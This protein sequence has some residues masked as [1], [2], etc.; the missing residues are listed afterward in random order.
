MYLNTYASE[1]KELE[2]YEIVKSVEISKEDNTYRIEVLRDYS[3]QN[4]CFCVRAYVRELVSINRESF[5]N[6]ATDN[7]LIEDRHIWAD[8]SDFPWVNMP[9]PKKA[10]SQA[11]GFLEERAHR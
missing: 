9:D 8:F 1:H 11:L 6:D 3:A 2:I 5:R 10:L 4:I 7:R